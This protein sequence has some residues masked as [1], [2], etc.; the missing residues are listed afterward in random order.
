MRSLLKGKKDGPV[1]SD[2]QPRTEGIEALPEYSGYR[3][4]GKFYGIA[5]LKGMMEAV[6][7]KP[8]LSPLL[9]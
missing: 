3:L 2:R 4:L 8:P 6:Y 1:R 9:M 7:G 5:Y